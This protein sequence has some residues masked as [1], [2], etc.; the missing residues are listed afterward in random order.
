[1]TAQYGTP[2]REVLKNTL[3]A[4]PPIAKPT[5]VLDETYTNEFPADQALVKMTALTIEGRALI[6]AFWIAITHGE[7]AALDVPVRASVVYGTSIPTMRAEPM[8][9][10]QIR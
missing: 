7:L 2:C 9:K 5:K 6:W 3:G 8:L 10:R 1:M 4:C